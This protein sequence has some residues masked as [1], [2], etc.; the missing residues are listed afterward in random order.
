MRDVA[1]SRFKLSL[2]GRFALTGPQGPIELPGRKL[3]G[4]LAYLACAAPHPQ[5]REK[6]ATL[7]WGS[8]FEAQARSSLRQA[9]F[10]LRATLGKDVLLGDGEEVSLAPGSIDCDAV[11]LETLVREGSRASLA[12]AVDLYKG[13]LLED[14]SVD[15][16][17]WAEWL[18]GER[19]R[20]EHLAL[21]AMVR[22]A[23]LDLQ[24]DEPESALA[25]AT[26]AIAVSSTREDAHRLAIR[27]LAAAGRRADALRHYQELERLLRRELDVEPD[28]AT[29]AVARELRSRR[30]AASAPR[31]E[32]ITPPRV[33]PAYP[34]LPDRPSIAVLP[35]ANMGGD[36]EQ[37]YFADGMVD[38]ILMA[39]SRVRWLFVIARQSSFVYK[40]RVADV[41]QIG[42]ELGVRYVVEGSV[43]KSGDRVRITAQLIETESGA[44]VWAD[45]Y[46]GDMGNIFALQDEI[47]GRIV[48]AVESSVQAAEVKRTYAKPTESLTAYDLY[49]RALPA[50][51]GQTQDEYRRTA[52]LLGDAIGADPEYAEALGTLTD[53]VTTRTLQGWHESWTSGVEEACRL[54]GRALAAGPDNSTCVAVA[55]STYAMLSQRF[56]EAFELANRALALHPNSLLVRNRAG[57]A[58]VVNGELDKAVAQC[59]AA[60]RMNPLDSRKAATFTSGLLSC[61]HY[62]A[63]RFEESIQAGRRALLFT[64]QNN[65][66]RKYVAA[67]LAQLGRTD[68]ARAEIA[69]LLKYQPDASLRLFRQHGFRHKW[70]AELHMEGLRRAGLREE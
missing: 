12:A 65:T 20:L 24:A 32:E 30:P 28:D 21:D 9:L 18:E 27:A 8:H 15:D 14:V 69:E 42:R 44:H 68:E 23:E 53:S 11:R 5:S 62:L 43:R 16:D 51:F 10:R 61:A 38:D 13:P 52:A 6:L 39:L 46:E 36:P 55:A 50:Y 56:D 41:Q 34:P 22:S 26:R 67:S 54:A 66:A 35:F 4:L 25:A 47:T 37:E 7:L 3:V 70:M 60:R 48:A 57:I 40:V 49:L 31:A 58:Y 17:G 1:S 45:R 2:L 19:R 64:P 29:K 63:R 59:E 33:E